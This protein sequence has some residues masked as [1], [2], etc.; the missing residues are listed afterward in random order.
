MGAQLVVACNGGPLS[1]EQGLLF[2]PLK[3]LFFP[4]VNDA[5]W[6]IGA[7]IDC[8]MKFPC[9]AM[10]C[11][12]ESIRF[13][14]AG[15]LKRYEEAFNQFGPGMYGTFSSNLVRP[16]LNTTGFAISPK[17]LLSSPRPQNKKDRYSWEHGE[18]SIWKR[19]SQLGFPTKLVTWD[20]IYDPR[21]WR[22]PK[23]GLWCGD[24]SDC[25]MWCSHT[26]RF[27]EADPATRIR[28]Q[29]G[30]DGLRTSL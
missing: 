12:G 11:C 17:F 28:W 1:R 16:H 19:V 3:A 18:A 26:T 15:W 24:Q 23:N 4:K 6:D 22:K 10:C 8:A 30:A 7:Y 25:L 13:H 29:Q 5:S 21:D 9:D 27:F 14:R 2:E 20:S